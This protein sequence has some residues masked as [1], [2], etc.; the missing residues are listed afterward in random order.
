ASAFHRPRAPHRRHH[1]CIAGASPSRHV[2]RTKQIIPWCRDTRVPIPEISAAGN[3]TA[4]TEVFLGGRCKFAARAWLRPGRTRG[5]GHPDTLVWRSSSRTVRSSGRAL[6]NMRGETAKF[7]RL[8]ISK[9]RFWLRFYRP[10]NCALSMTDADK[11]DPDAASGGSSEIRSRHVR[12][13]AT[14]AARIGLI[15]SFDLRYPPRKIRTSK[16]RRIAP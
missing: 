5:G 7:C 3:S 1:G 6:R 2:C 14:A 16:A 4:P 8:R 12:A 10:A 13:L 11:F 15:E 9:G